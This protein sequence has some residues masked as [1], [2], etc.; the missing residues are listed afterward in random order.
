M[1][2]EKKEKNIDHEKYKKEVILKEFVF[3]TRLNPAL[4]FN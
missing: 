3:L 4:P 2:V 1:K